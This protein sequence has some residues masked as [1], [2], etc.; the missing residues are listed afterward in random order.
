MSCFKIFFILAKILLIIGLTKAFAKE[1][2]EVIVAKV[3]NF[4]ITAQDVLNAT[5]NLPKKTREKPLSEIYPK[6]VNELINQH[7]I[8]MEAYKANLDK[9]KVILELVKKNKEQLMAKYWLNNFLSNQT[10]EENIELFY[11]K[12]LQN[13]KTYKEYNASHILVKEENDALKIIKKIKA[14]SEFSEFAKK[15]SIGPSKK[16]GGNLGW[17]GPGQM[18]LEFENATFKLKKG[19]ITKEPVKTQ[20]GYH[21]ILLNDIRDSKP[22]LLN[23]VRQKIINRI[24][25]NSLLNL[26]KE[27]RK[28]QDISIIEFTKVVKEINN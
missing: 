11:N 10:K 18:V 8:T 2:N 14:R 21:I 27:I 5:N 13:F 26:E 17:F 19:M 22:K 7:L 15:Y 28:N 24:K 9:K 12:Y 25:Q 1:P 16:N 23:D 20:F 6:I 4:T 3:N